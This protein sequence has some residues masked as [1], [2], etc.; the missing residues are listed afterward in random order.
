MLHL[1]RPKGRLFY[2][3]RYLVFVIVSAGMFHGQEPAKTLISDVVY[4]ADGTPAGG[5]LQITWPTFTTA[6]GKAVAAGN[7]S[8]MIGAGGTIAIELAPNEGASPAG[9]YYRVV[10]SLNE[11][12]TNMH[13]LVGNGKPGWIHELAAR[14]DRHEATLQHARGM[15]AALAGLLTLVHLAVD[16]LKWRH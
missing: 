9:T 1:G 10:L 2:F 4:R 15:T 12:K 3:C 16:Y 7:K 8:V 14:V 11:L 5:N 13:W 6:D